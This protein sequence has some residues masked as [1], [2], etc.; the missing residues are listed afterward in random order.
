MSDHATLIRQWRAT[1]IMIFI[2]AFGVV[3]LLVS[4]ALILQITP[5]TWSAE[6]P[7]LSRQNVPED[8]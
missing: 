5:D 3:L 4:L 1:A 7:S 2:T 6:N 8:T